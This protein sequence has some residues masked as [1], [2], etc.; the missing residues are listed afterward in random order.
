MNDKSFVIGEGAYGCIH[1]PSLTCKDAKIQNYKNKV[2]KLLEREKAKIELEEYSS[3]ENADASRE[4]YLGPP[5]ECDVANTPTNIQAIEKCKNGPELLKKLNNLSL[6][7]ME[8]GGINL[9]DFVDLMETWSATPE[10]VE[11]VDIFVIEL[12]RIFHGIA[13]FIE[14]GILHYDIKPQNIVYNTEKGRMN[15]ID[16]GLTVSL[17]DKLAQINASNNGMARYH[18]SYPFESFFLN[19]D[20][21][22]QFSKMAKN[23]KVEYYQSVLQKIS[24]E[25]TDESKAI[26]SFY[27]FVMDQNTSSNVFKEHMS[28]F[29][30]TL[31]VEMTMKNYPMFI[32]KSITTVDVYG[33]GITLLYVLKKT[34]RLLKE[35]L[36]ISL[37]DLGLDM[38][39]ADLAKR[40]T[41]IDALMKY[42]TI[43]TEN[44]LMNKYNISF[45]DHKIVQGGPIPQNIEQSIES[46]KIDDVLLND[47]ALEKNAVS[48]DILHKAPSSIKTK[49]KTV[50][51]RTAIK[52][53]KK[54]TKTVKQFPNILQ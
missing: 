35:Q 23:K 29:Y 10:N 6:L 28:G 54:P 26:R 48:V 44:G 41:A 20:D 7:I 53:P 36:Y 13:V 27:S 9:K 43:L 49:G 40:V 14:K 38:V 52:R 12:H 24:N 17:K 45:A 19:K 39:N 4:Y 42:E 2:S 3:I 51:K 32:K 33:L 31:V 5:V 8:D 50:K 18:W 21:Y 46:I 16:F 47:T 25:L 1:K 30:Q 37:Y 34:K 15:I 11:K 22:T